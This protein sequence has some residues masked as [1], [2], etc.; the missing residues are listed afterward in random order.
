MPGEDYR[1]LF[2]AERALMT[3]AYRVLDAGTEKTGQTCLHRLLEL[4]EIHLDTVK[5]FEM[6]ADP[7]RLAQNILRTAALDP[8]QFMNVPADRIN[9]DDHLSELVH[10]RRSKLRR[11]SDELKRLLSSPELN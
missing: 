10:R 4:A 2:E 3:T 11:A 8:R 1:Q 7:H 9:P 6:T 5:D